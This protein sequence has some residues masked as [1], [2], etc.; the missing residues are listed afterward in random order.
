[1]KGD[2]K[3]KPGIEVGLLGFNRG[4]TVP[5][6]RYPIRP[7]QFNFEGTK[8]EYQLKGERIV[9]DKLATC[10]C[11]ESP[12]VTQEIDGDWCVWCEG[13]HATEVFAE[14]ESEARRLWNEQFED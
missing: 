13:F 7:A 10:V 14:T 11:G 12:R 1:M 2:L 5:S 4:D 9:P 8:A 6:G 3:G